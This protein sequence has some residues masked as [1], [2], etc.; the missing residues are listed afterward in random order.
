LPNSKEIKNPAKTEWQRKF[1]KLDCYDP[2]ISNL[3]DRAQAFC[4]RWASQD[5]KK[6]LLVLVGE[7]GCAKTHVAKAVYEFCT[8]SRFTLWPTRHTKLMSTKFIRW[9]EEADFLCTSDYQSD[10]LMQEL[11]S[12]D[13]LIIDDIG[14]ENDAWKK[15]TNKLCQVFSRRENKFTVTTTNIQP[16]DWASKFDTRIADRLMRNSEV[17]DLFG[18]ESYTMI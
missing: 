13:L 15:A 16:Q 17:I 3:A 6:S 14:A 11:F 8:A 12:R 2:K 9:P 7:S 1:L 4:A 5:Y 18:V 10:W